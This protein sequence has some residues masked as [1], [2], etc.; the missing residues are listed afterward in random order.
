MKEKRRLY[1]DIS[2]GIGMLLVVI[3]HCVNKD[4]LLHNWIFSFHM[5]LFFCISGY[6]FRLDKYNSFKNIMVDK[7]KRLLVPYILFSLLGLF[8]SLLIPRW[9]QQVDIQG[10]LVDIYT[11]YPKLSH[12]T[13]TWF[14][15]SLFLCMVIW[16]TINYLFKNYL[17]R[18]G[19]IILS[20]SIGAVISKMHEVVNVVSA[21]EKTINLPGGRLPLTIDASFTAFVFF[22]IGNVLRVNKNNKALEDKRYH[23]L[24]V[25][26]ISL[27]VNIVV[28]LFLNSR[29][30]IH[31]CMEG[32]T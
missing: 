5:P 31:G 32:N 15:I 9:R 18:I 8:I 6:C 28:S 27:G 10:I 24:L 3:G 22:A 21:S 29:V 14:L 13:S 19:F 30:N 20:G 26:M 17:I 23:T 11:G 12:I 16:W 25:G 7:A 2:K 4:T 1:L